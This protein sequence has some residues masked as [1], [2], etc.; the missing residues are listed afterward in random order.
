MMGT[1]DKLCTDNNPPSTQ[2]WADLQTCVCAKACPKECGNN[3]CMMMAPS[4]DCTTCLSNTG[5]ILAAC[6]NEATACVGDQ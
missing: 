1:P 3:L 5:G 2:I 4:A 6:P